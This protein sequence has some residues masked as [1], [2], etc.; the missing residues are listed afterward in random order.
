MKGELARDPKEHQGLVYVDYERD[1]DRVFSALAKL[2]KSVSP[3]YGR[4]SAHDK[5]KALQAWKNGDFRVM[6]CTQAFGLG[7]DKSD[8]RVVVRYGC[9]QSVEAWVQE[10]GRAG[11]DG[12]PSRAVLYH[13]DADLQRLAYWTK[14]RPESSHREE[15]LEPFHRS[16]CF[17][18]CQLLNQCRRQHLLKF[19]GEEGATSNGDT[20][21]DVCDQCQ[22]TVKQD[23]RLELQLLLLALEDL[24]ARGERK[25]AEWIHGSHCQ[26]M[27]DFR[28]IRLASP[29]FGRGRGASRSSHSVDWW[30]SFIRQCSVACLVTREAVIGLRGKPSHPFA[31]ISVTPNEQGR[32]T[33]R[34]GAPLLL[35]DPEEQR[36]P[37]PNSASAEEHSCAE[38]SSAQSRKS[39]SSKPPEVLKDLMK[40]RCRWR[41][42]EETPNWQFPGF[43]TEFPKLLIYFENAQAITHCENSTAVW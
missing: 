30:R 4:L 13:S 2:G 33:V 38:S 8:V 15:L 28:D 6:V 43:D 11:R 39:S 36:F 14:S 17:A 22:Q 21:C 35:P 5:K 26:W 32:D 40:D 7:I 19:F 37:N 41:R 24:G 18:S 16:W 10:F 12:L 42:A 34:S 29:A 20:C 3:F 9:P 31:L 23:L 1:V 27:E 25:L